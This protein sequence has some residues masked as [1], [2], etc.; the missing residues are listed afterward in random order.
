M[1][2]LYD[3]LVAD[4]IQNRAKNNPQVLSLSYAILQEKRH[5]IDCAKRTR[6]LAVID[7]LPEDVLDILAV[8]LRTPFYNGTFAIATKRRLI[9]DT[10]IYYSIMGTPEAVNRMLSAVFPGSYI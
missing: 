8:E 2:K 9:K 3:G 1:T 6:T 4:L 7:E 10:L 5:L